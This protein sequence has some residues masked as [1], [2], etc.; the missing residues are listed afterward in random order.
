MQIHIQNCKYKTCASCTYDLE[1][2]LSIIVFYT[3][4]RRCD[5]KSPCPIFFYSLY[6]AFGSQLLQLLIYCC[7]V[8]ADLF[9]HHLQAHIACGHF[10]YVF[11]FSLTHNLPKEKK[12][13]RLSICQCI[14]LNMITVIVEVNSKAT[15]QHFSISGRERLYGCPACHYA[16]YLIL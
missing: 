16:L 5:N 9:C 12:Y 2:T 6:V 11:C 8:N 14:A 3:L 1:N 13:L 10:L 7:N 4:Y 15:T